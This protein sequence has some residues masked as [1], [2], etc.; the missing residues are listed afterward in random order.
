MTS[1]RQQM[2]KV[3]NLSTTNKSTDNPIYKW[4]H[5]RLFIQ[6]NTLESSNCWLRKATK[7]KGEKLYW[8]ETFNVVQCKNRKCSKICYC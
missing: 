7:R 6:V 3:K 5:N 2:S 4:I 1:E 8:Y